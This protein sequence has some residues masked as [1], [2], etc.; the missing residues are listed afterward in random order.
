MKNEDLIINRPDWVTKGQHVTAVGA[1]LFFWFALFYLWQPAISLVAWA[2]NVKLFYSHMVVLGGYETLLD[3]W[4]SYA[5]VISLM[6]G[7]L[8]LWAKIN[9]WRFKGVERRKHIPVAADEAISET[10]GVEPDQLR[11]W[12]SMKSV[13]LDIDENSQ[14]QGV[15]LHE[16]QVATPELSQ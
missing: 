15:S 16:P 2:F 13:I 8:I 5:L 11:G 14:V 10:F 1:T 7:S 6:G 4:V 12:R 3:V 9:E